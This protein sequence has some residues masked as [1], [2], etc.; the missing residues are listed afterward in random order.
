LY[1]I[2]TITINDWEGEAALPEAKSLAEAS[3]PV[4]N[5]IQDNSG[6]LTVDAI[7]GI[8]YHIAH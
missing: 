4:L 5:L 8:K 6:L 2:L 3:C 1:F 7:Y